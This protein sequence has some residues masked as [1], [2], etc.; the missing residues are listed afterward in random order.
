MCRT[1]SLENKNKGI[2]MSFFFQ[3]IIILLETKFFQQVWKLQH[4]L[5]IGNAQTKARLNDE[6]PKKPIVNMKPFLLNVLR[7]KGLIRKRST[8]LQFR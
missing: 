5:K 2:Q 4:L 3:V 6:Y 7:A 8:L 1:T